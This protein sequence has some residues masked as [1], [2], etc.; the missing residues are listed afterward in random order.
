MGVTA[1]I[2]VFDSGVGGLTVLRAIHAAL[3]E[4]STY[5]LGDSARMPYGAKSQETVTRYALAA[6]DFLC[7]LRIKALVV[8]C[9]TASSVALPALREHVQ[10]P[11]L[12]V[13]EAGVARALASTR[14][15]AVAVAATEGTAR[16]G[17][18]QRALT[19]AVPGL[20]VV[21]RACPLFAPLVEEGTVE[22]PL[23]EAVVRHHLGGLAD[24]GVDTV[25][26]GCTHY[27]LLR[28]ALA[29]VL[30]PGVEIVDGAESVA[31]ELGRILG[32]RGLRAPAGTPAVRRYFATDAPDRLQ[33]LGS[34]FLGAPVPQVELADLFA[35]GK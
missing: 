24:E 30:G 2:G 13:V 26:L 19:R 9:S 17:A 4:E 15:G 29:A 28:H 32:E 5:Y 10:V 35:P 11:V 31:A 27:P 21:A 8:A 34:R 7:E 14:G 3:P 18:Y 1:G 6:A 22:G 33:A 16:S 20:R 23:A 12:G 25:V